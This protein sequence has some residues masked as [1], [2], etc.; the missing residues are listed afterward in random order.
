MGNPGGYNFCLSEHR[1]V[2]KHKI[3]RLLSF[4]TS[5]DSKC[6][7]KIK[8]ENYPGNRVTMVCSTC[9][10]IESVSLEKNEQTT[11]DAAVFFSP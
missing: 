5:P 7:T 10:S 8:Y 11:S 1:I 4:Q 2:G 6:G 9:G 3:S